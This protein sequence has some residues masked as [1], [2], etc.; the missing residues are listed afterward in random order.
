MNPSLS[1]SEYSPS[2][3]SPC[4]FP[5]EFTQVMPLATAWSIVRRGLFSRGDVP[6]PG[7]SKVQ[8]NDWL[9]TSTPSAIIHSTVS[10]RSPSVYGLAMYNDTSGAT[11]TTASATPV[12]CTD[13]VQY[14]GSSVTPLNV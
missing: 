7:P 8:D 5:A 11:S 3:A 10:R 1:A 12:P 2:Q 13:P 9:M 4:S 6:S 14:L